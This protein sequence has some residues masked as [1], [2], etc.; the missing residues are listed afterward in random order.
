MIEEGVRLEFM[1]EKMESLIKKN[2]ND[3]VNYEEN[4]KIYNRYLLD[5]NLSLIQIPFFLNKASEIENSISRNI[6][7]NLI[8]LDE[9]KIFIS[10]K[11]ITLDQNR[12]SLFHKFSA[13]NITYFFSIFVFSITFLILIFINYVINQNKN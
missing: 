8:I 7:N 4:N 13:I 9:N 3:N 10:E 1:I 6:T 11:I 2:D 12:L 5:Y